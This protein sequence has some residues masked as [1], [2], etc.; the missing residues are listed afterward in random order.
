M[1][2]AT[3]DSY[4]G[5]RDDVTSL[6]PAARRVLDVGCSD[7]SLGA[8][9]RSGGA[10]VWGIDYDHGFATQAAEKLD[11]VLD[12][13][14]VERLAELDGER[15]DAVICA[16]VLEHLVDPWDVLLQIG[17]LLSPGGAV[18]VSLPN[19]RFY[20][21]FVELGLR[22]RW[23][24]RDRGVHDRTHLRWFTDAD[25]RA[26]FADTGFAVT[27]AVTNYRLA[28][29]PMHPLN[30]HARRFARGPLKGVLAYQH[31]YRLSAL[32]SGSASAAVV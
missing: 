2:A 21:T 28:D 13:D 3:V 8:S 9:L 24:R 6:V 23:P 27:D 26:M 20:T 25:A 18:V 15:F 10:E 17:E 5:I 11:R 7:G 29:R 12:G 31:L 1:R 30:P 19:V 14:A 4:T 22:A 16:D 32:P